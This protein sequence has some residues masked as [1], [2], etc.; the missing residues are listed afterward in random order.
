MTLMS[1]KSILCRRGILAVLVLGK[2]PDDRYPG[3]LDSFSPGNVKID[4]TEK[5]N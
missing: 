4:V 3:S 1:H 2:K 5:E